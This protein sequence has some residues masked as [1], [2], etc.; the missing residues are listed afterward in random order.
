M[1]TI[2]TLISGAA[3]S[4]LC[5]AETSCRVN[6][7]GVVDLTYEA[8]TTTVNVEAVYSYNHPC[9]MFNQ[10]EFDR[11]KTMLDNGTAPSAVQEE[12]ENLLSSKYTQLT[13]TSS[14]QTEIIRGGTTEGQSQNYVYAMRDAAAAYQ[15]ALVWKL[16]GDD[17]YAALAVSIL[18]DWAATCVNI[19]S[20]DYDYMLAAGAQ[21]YTFA[22][23]GELLRDYEGWETSDFEDFKDWMVDLF[24]AKNREFLEHASTTVCKEHYWSNWDLVNM[25]SYLAI[26]ILTEDDDIV[27]YVVNYFYNGEGNG[28]IEKLIRGVHE[29]PLGTGE[30]ICQNQESGRDQGHALMST[31]V[32]ANLCQMAYTL[33]LQ[34]TDVTELDFF[35]ANDNAVLGMS[36][37]VALCNLRNGTDN[38]N[39]TG[40]WLISVEKI[41]FTEFD[42]CYDCDCT[43]WSSHY[44]IHTAVSETDRGDIRPYSEIF[45]NHYA[46]VKGL[47]SGYVYTK[48]LAD[49]IRPE[50]GAGEPELRYGDNSGAFDQLGWGTLMLYRE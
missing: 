25:C 38:E 17:D 21:G 24:G 36:E 34:N 2:M 23:A 9:A 13:Y 50:G 5:M 30:T 18:N 12:Y 44:A 46:N 49:K 37:Y 10:D 3:M 20:T 27:N 31:A 8:D 42:Y 7:F 43:N 41:P 35:A 40:S 16:T 39:S 19:T 33:Y 1:K 45:Y 48:Q 28:C 32:T 29:D 15:M 14:P 6:E 26:G 22:N 47:S 11:V 4:L